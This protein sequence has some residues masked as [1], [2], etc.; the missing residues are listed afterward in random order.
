[1]TGESSHIAPKASYAPIIS[2]STIKNQELL[3]RVVTI[4]DQKNTET[5]WS[6]AQH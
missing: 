3:P 2:T 5:S 4:L 6:S 1:M